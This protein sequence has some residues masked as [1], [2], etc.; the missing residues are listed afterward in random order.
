LASGSSL[1]IP[2]RAER[3]LRLVEPIGGSAVGAVRGHAPALFDDLVGAQ[4]NR[5]GYGKAERT[6]GFFESPTQLDFVHFTACSRR[7]L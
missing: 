7:L 6:R 1:L 2:L 5:W 3:R 4:Q